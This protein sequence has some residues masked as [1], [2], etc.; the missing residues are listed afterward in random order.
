MYS[1]V[2]WLLSGELRK[3]LE[4]GYFFLEAL[5]TPGSW[6]DCPPSGSRALFSLF[7][8]FL[9]EGSHVYQTCSCS[10]RPVARAMTHPPVA[11]TPM[12]KLLICLA[13]E[14]TKNKPVKNG[15]LNL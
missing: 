4:I 13:K 14:D 15:S 3:A 10:C 9:L 2:V 8:V 7:I 12:V 11:V 6:G 1:T 5:K